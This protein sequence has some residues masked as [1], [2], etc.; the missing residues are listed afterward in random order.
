[1]QKIIFF[2]KALS[3]LISGRNTLKIK[4]VGRLGSTS[5]TVVLNAVKVA[6]WTSFISFRSCLWIRWTWQ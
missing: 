1:M 5:L 6:K 2:D 4:Q 3:R